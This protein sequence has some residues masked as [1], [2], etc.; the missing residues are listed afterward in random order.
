[1][2]NSMYIQR[3]FILAICLL[4]VWNPAAQAQQGGDTAQLY[5]SLRQL[6]T[7][8]EASPVGFS[9]RYSYA[10]EQK[11]NV[12]LDSMS[13]SLELSGISAR[14]IVDNMVTV[15]NSRYNITVFPDD[16]LIYVAKPSAVIQADP[17]AQLRQ[18]I[19]SSG[20]SHCSVEENAEEQKI[21]VAFREG[22]NCREM[23]IRINPKTGYMRDVVYVLK[24]SLLTGGDVP[25]AETTAAYGEYAVV[26][27]DFFNYR[28]L[29]EGDM[30]RFD[31]RNYFSREG[32]EFK[33]SPAYKDYQIFKGSPNL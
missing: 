24:T 22:G 32:D 28:K 26:R 18:M 5:R 14:Y 7:A 13:G 1:M 25:E 10:S 12:M 33:P 9:I 20:I 30:N 17:V 16:R 27:M 29:A 6:Q 8:L 3:F 31:E 21:I 19:A 15:S 4:G 11:P 23:I 2:L